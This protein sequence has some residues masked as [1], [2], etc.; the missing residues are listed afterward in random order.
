MR[1][2]RAGRA[3]AAMRTMSRFLPRAISCRSA[4]STRCGPL[5][6]AGITPYRAVRRALPWL[7]GGGRVLVIG[8][9]GLGQFAIQYLRLM[10][11]CS[12]LAVDPNAAKRNKARELGA[13]DA[14]PPDREAQDC[15]AAFDFVGTDG[16]LALAARAVR[17]GGLIM[18]VGEAGGRIP[19][20]FG[21]A[22]HE[23]TITTSVWGSQGDLAAVLDLARAGRLQWEVEEFA[24]ADV[25]EALGRLRRGEIAGRAVLR[26]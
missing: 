4:A 15:I 11:E 16:S 5:A 21:A 12:I 19:F 23:V 13:D 20:G 6:D 8:A 9:G 24:L 7:S 25:N 3:M 22:E 17:R 10:T 1:P 18:L 2:S 14:L 26:P